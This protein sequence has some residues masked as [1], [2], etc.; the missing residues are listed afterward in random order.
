M[1]IY[2]CAK[3]NFTPWSIRAIIV[4]QISGRLFL[5]T[6]YFYACV[7]VYLVFFHLVKSITLTLQC[8]FLKKLLNMI[9]MDF[10]Q[11]FV[12]SSFLDRD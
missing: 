9:W 2:K 5:A 8:Y 7:C 11:S 3:G 1:L 12:C 4:T 10:H 6:R